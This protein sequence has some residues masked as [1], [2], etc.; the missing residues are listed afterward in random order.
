MRRANA[1]E[2]EQT[3]R[4]LRSGYCKKF[5]E[6]RNIA[7]RFGLRQRMKHRAEASVECPCGSGLKYKHCC[8]GRA[9]MERTD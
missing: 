3:W 7:L 1:I 5:G 6:M 8:L 4:N 9:D 2:I